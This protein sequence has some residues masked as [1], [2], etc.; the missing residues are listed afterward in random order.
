MNGTL[1]RSQ[2]RPPVRTTEVRMA[3]TYGLDSDA[4]SVL[5]VLERLA[6]SGRVAVASVPT[7]LFCTTVKEDE[8]RLM[9]LA[10]LFTTSL[11]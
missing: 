1:E 9:P 8:A 6:T 11:S 7:K 2:A 4:R 10:R 3:K 5:A